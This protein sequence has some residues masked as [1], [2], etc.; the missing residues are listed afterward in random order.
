MMGDVPESGEELIRPLSF[1]GRRSMVVG[2]SQDP[3]P[4]TSLVQAP[5]AKLNRI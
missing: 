3:P 2:N 1:R 5:P 4:L